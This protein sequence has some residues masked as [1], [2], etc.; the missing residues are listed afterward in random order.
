MPE[1]PAPPPADP[2]AD[3][4]PK[5][6]GGVLAWLG[7]ATSLTYSGL[8]YAATADTIQTGQYRGIKQAL[9][10]M[11]LAVVVG[12]ALAVYFLLFPHLPAC[13]DNEVRDALSRAYQAS[14]QTAVT[15]LDG[16]QTIS[17]THD[18]AECRGRVQLASGGRESVAYVIRLVKRTLE[19]TVT[20]ADAG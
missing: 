7:V 2:S 13:G 1:P 19:V 15:A 11:G 12:G 10:Y 9:T 3:T 20:K 18:V 5:R 8:D 17:R 16:V 4:Q 14:R 6:R